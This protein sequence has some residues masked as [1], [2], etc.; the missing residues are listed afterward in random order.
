MSSGYCLVAEPLHLC[1]INR[2]P[3]HCTLLL[4]KDQQVTLSLPPA[5]TPIEALCCERVCDLKQLGP[6]L[7]SRALPNTLF[8]DVVKD[9]LAAGASLSARDD[10]KQTVLHH[11]ARADPPLAVGLF[12]S[13][14]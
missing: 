3:R 8:S 9:L 6:S 11:A 14:A 12:T 1:L 10:S 4:V 5:L 13:S 7:M 2:E